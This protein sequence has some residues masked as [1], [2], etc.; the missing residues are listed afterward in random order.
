MGVGVAVNAFPVLRFGKW[1][2][3][4]DWKISCPSH[5]LQLS[6]DSKMELSASIEN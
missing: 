6:N 4:F 1:E 2:I 5:S 3:G